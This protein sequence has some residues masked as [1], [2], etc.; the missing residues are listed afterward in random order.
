VSHKDTE[1]SLTRYTLA[2]E[3]MFL[4]GLGGYTFIGRG[5][6]GDELLSRYVRAH[7]KYP[8]RQWSKEE[9][10]KLCGLAERLMLGRTA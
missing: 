8:S 2:D 7:R 4:L 3:Q 6:K 9:V 10:E 1:E 5:M